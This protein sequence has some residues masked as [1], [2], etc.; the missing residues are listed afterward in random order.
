[1]DFLLRRLGYVSVIAEG[2][3]D[4]DGEDSKRLDLARLDDDGEVVVALEAERMNG[5]QAQAVPDDYDTLAAHDPEEAI[6]LAM[7]EDGA[8][9]L[10]DALN[11]PSDGVPRVEKSYSRS[12]RSQKFSIDTPGLTEVFIVDHLLEELGIE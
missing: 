4:H 11:D 3:K 10:L 2:R 12:T 6:W 8:H 9:K 7:D 1:V 5:R